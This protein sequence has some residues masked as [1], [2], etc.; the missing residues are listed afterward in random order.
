MSLLYTKEQKELIAL[1]K[2]MAEN[3]IKPHVQ[4]LDEKGECPRELFKYAFD[5][6]LHMLEIPEEYGG[7][8]LSY[9]TTAMIFEELAKVD[10]GY[11]ITLVTTFVALRNVILS[12][13][14]DQGKY[15]AD[16]IGKGNFAGF[17]LTEPNAG[18]DP[19]GMRGTAVKDGDEYIL[20]ATKTFITNGAL[21][22]VFVG[23]FKTNPEAGNKGISAFIVD[24]NTPGI[25]I[26]K[27]EDKMG[28]RLSNTTDVTFENVRVPASNML[29]EEGSGFKLALNSLNLSRAFVATLAVGIMQ[30]ALDESVKYAKERKQF[31]KPIIKFQMVQ[32][33]LADMAIKI[34]ASRALVNNTMKLMDNGNLVR[35]EGAITK[36]FVS[37]CAQEV[38]SNAVQIFGGYGYSKEYPV[39]KLMRDCKVFQ[40]FEGANQIQRMTIA[41]ALEKEYK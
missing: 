5:M 2:E 36:A 29:G 23:I 3:E 26:G 38:T 14:K 21:A 30:R 31:G 41:G 4:E 25:T 10:A 20:N 12:G 6:G 11:A 34:E 7:T 33:M 8:G 37:D 19:A 15:F 22:S 24:A 39:E 16:I 18:S 9:E 13:T 32:Q 27:H 35:K 28:L 40:I 1:V 17:A